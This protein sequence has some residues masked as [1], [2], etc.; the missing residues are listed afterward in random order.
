MS[1]LDSFGFE[2]GQDPPPQEVS[3]RLADHPRACRQIELARGWGG[4]GGFALVGLLALDSGLSPAAAGLRA[5]LGGVLA[6]MVCWALAVLVWRHL[7]VAEEAA[8]RAHAEERRAALLAEI[9]RRRAAL[10]E[11]D[12]R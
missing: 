3:I 1:P 8:A 2:A 5:L 7:A 11:E 6:Y 9:E 12:D 10:D 4:V